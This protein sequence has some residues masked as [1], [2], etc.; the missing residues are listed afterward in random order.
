MTDQNDLAIK[1]VIDDILDY[2]CV[3]KITKT[4][5]EALYRVNIDWHS[6]ECIAE[7]KSLFLALNS[8]FEKM[9]S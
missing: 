8:A 3:I 4:N 7:N 6:D 1:T 5:G 9:I 2:N